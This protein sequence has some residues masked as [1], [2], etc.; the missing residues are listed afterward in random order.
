MTS[1]AP[2]NGS[3]WQATV[4]LEATRVQCCA[5]EELE[6]NRPLQPATQGERFHVRDPTDSTGKFLRMPPN[7]D[8]CE[9]G[10][11]VGSPLQGEETG[12]QS[13]GD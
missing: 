8:S 10:G 9:D 13:L 7:F 11:K 6:Q 12:D 5:A 3:V 2:H 4:W 1:L